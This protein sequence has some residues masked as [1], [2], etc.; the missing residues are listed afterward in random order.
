[1]RCLLLGSLCYETAR[2]EDGSSLWHRRATVYSGVYPFSVYNSALFEHLGS[3]EFGVHLLPI[4][5]SS[6]VI[7]C[8]MYL[9]SKIWP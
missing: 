3:R 2:D 1:M 7:I 4:K 9:A 5:H 6:D 8:H